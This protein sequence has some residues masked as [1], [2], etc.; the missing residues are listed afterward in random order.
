MYLGGS[1]CGIRDD[2][3]VWE[4]QVSTV[5]WTTGHTLDGRDL[6]SYSGLRLVSRDNGCCYLGGLAT[7]NHWWGIQH[8]DELRLQHRWCGSELG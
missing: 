5:K 8:R 7:G 3:E 4:N 6:P 2:V 1:S